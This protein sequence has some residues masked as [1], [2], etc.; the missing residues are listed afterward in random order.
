M[1]YIPAGEFI[2][3]SDSGLDD[4]ALPEHRVYLDAFWIDKFE[5]TNGQYNKCVDALKCLPITLKV[6][7]I[8]SS[9]FGNPKFD[10]YPVVYTYWDDAN[11]YCLWVG[12]RLPTEAEWEKAARGTDGRS[13]P[14]GNSFDGRR[15]NSCDRN[16]T[17]RGSN[18]NIDD[19][20]A[21]TAPIGSFPSG[22]S[23][24]GVHDMVGNVWEWVAD[25]YDKNYYKTSPSNNPKG[26]PTGDL[27]VV[28]GGSWDTSYANDLFTFTRTFYYPPDARF[29]D[30]GFRCAQNP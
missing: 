20:Y 24:Y 21:E 22:V 25:W 19:G 6:H 1:I 4:D 11:K 30:L 18:K 13:Y 8:D 26:P 2:M 9:N 27:R 5:V 12:K 15:L 16:C 17:D 23:P 28:R 7:Y 3:G 29:G 10:N 14:W